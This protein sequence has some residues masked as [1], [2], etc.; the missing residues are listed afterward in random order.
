[1]LTHVHMHTNVFHVLLLSNLCVPFSW[2]TGELQSTGIV[3]PVTSD[4]YI[5]LLGKLKEEGI[6]YR[7]ESAPL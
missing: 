3:R 6:V 7:V 2:L 1:M 5:P 4:V